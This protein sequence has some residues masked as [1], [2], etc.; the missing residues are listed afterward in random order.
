MFS[1]R[2]PVT[3]CTALQL[4]Q[5][6]RQ[7]PVFVLALQTS[8]AVQESCPKSLAVDFALQTFDYLMEQPLAMRA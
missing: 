8:Q 3:A 7:H 5:P 1:S 2:E 4:L 6:T